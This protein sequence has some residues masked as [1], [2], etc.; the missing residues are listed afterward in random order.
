MVPALMLCYVVLVP[1]S[2]ADWA[3]KISQAALYRADFVCQTQYDGCLVRMEK[4]KN[5]HYQATCRR[6]K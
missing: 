4:K 5:N 1:S 2:L 6:L 3:D